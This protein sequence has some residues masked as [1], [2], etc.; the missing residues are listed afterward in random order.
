MLVDV[1]V[2]TPRDNHTKYSIALT[3]LATDSHNCDFYRSISRRTLRD[4]QI[5]VINSTI[6]LQPLHIT[7]QNVIYLQLVNFTTAGT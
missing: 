1:W 7:N 6:L 5:L 2:K 3:L 4:V